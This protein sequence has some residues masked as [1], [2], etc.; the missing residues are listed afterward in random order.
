MMYIEISDEIILKHAMYIVNSDI[1]YNF[2]RLK[3]VDIKDSSNVKK[4]HIKFCDFIIN[5]IDN[6]QSNIDNIEKLNENIFLAKP[7]V[8]NTALKKIQKKFPLISNKINSKNYIYDKI[9]YKDIVLDSIGYE[10]FSSHKIR[11]F[12]YKEKKFIKKYNITYINKRIK[13]IKD[14]QGDKSYNKTH[15]KILLKEIIL[16]SE[17]I[18]L[19][20]SDI[21]QL[22]NE[23]DTEFNK[24]KYNTSKDF[25]A[26]IKVYLKKINDIDLDN[27]SINTMNYNLYK[28]KIDL[29]ILEWSAYHFVL[30]LGLK[31]CPYCNRQYIT[32]LYSGNGKV[33]GDL[34][35]FYPKSKYPYFAMSIYNLVPCC[36]SC[37]SSLKGDIEFSYEENINPYDI[38]MNNYIKFNYIPKSLDSFY[39]NEEVIITIDEIY[40]DTND[41]QVKCNN[42]LEIFKIKELYQYHEDIV[43]SLIKKK[44]IYDKVYIDHIIE[45]YGI[46]KDR[47]DAISMLFKNQ[48]GIDNNSI[49]SKLVNDI[50][51]KLDIE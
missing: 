28:N 1:K 16:D 21:K 35:H 2:S 51:E 37:N 27:Q 12:F 41:I 7:D 8:L 38:D 33:R 40:D 49:L 14:A 24:N 5:E 42:N 29:D 15:F 9:T 22:V 39:G 30:Q 10:E 47:K 44:I 36:K 19:L 13:E 23:L 32:P 50:I 17:N 4:E 34:D 45:K 3:K 26:F 46:F 43:R 6:I 31:V 11:D 20:H 48:I 25:L 18:N